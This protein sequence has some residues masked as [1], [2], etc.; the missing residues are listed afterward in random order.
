MEIAIND[1]KEASVPNMQ[2]PAIRSKFPLSDR[3]S[4][5]LCSCSTTMPPAQI[6][7]NMPPL[8]KFEEQ[9]DKAKYANMGLRVKICETGS[10]LLDH[11]LIHPFV[12]VHI[13]S[14]ETYKYLPKSD[15][16]KP[17]VANREAAGFMDSGKH[18][19]KQ[20]ADFLLPFST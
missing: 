18:F 9:F 6:M 16:R 2:L 13:V 8:F 5:A 15:K 19:S 14:L 11:H 17:G 10:L 12:R 7:K 20:E 1:S 4:L 3:I